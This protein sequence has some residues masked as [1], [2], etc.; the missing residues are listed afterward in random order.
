MQGS[1]GVRELRSVRWWE[2]LLIG[3]AQALALLPG[4]SRSGCTMV[5][6]LLVGLKHEAA[7]HFSFLLATPII[8]GAGVLEV[9]HLLRASD[10]GPLSIALV[11]G[12]VAGVL[13]WL[14]TALL[15]RYFR[16]HE[17]HALYPFAYYC[18]A[19]GTLALGVLLFRRS[20]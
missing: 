9:P 5:A 3:A 10:H 17:L 20:G 11:A 16:H 7:A 15:M 6:G 4:F 18:W 12:V 19:V 1:R 2:A 13:A 8:L 14:S